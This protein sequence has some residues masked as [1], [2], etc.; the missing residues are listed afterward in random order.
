MKLLTKWFSKPT[1]YPKQILDPKQLALINEVDQ[2]LV[3]AHSTPRF[4]TQMKVCSTGVS[5]RNTFKS[6]ED[7]VKNINLEF[8]DSYI[9]RSIAFLVDTDGN[10][11]ILY[12]IRCDIG[13]DPITTTMFIELLG[14]TN[15]AR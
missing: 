13:S 15:D 2:A 5:F 14:R 1:N 9:P 8:G 7:I 10:W 12:A 6:L 4:G 11:I 3:N